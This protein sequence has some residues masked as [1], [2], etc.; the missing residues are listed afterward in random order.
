MYAFTEKFWSIQ[1]VPKLF[2][3]INTRGGEH[4]NKYI[5]IRNIWS[6]KAA[7]NVRDHFVSGADV[8][9]CVGVAVWEYVL[10]LKTALCTCHLTSRVW[11]S[12]SGGT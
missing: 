10:I 9:C 5:S 12:S 1:G 11:I 3:Q 6:L 2:V 4:Q 7:C 8:S